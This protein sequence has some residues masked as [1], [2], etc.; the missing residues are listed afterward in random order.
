MNVCSSVSVRVSTFCSVVV[1]FVVTFFIITSN[2]GYFGAVCVVPMI[3]FKCFH[4]SSMFSISSSLLHLFSQFLLFSIFIS[5]FISLLCWLYS[6]YSI[7][8]LFLTFF[9]YVFFVFYHV[10]YQF[11]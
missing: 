5:L 3:C 7:V 11:G 4:E 2:V 10:C 1:I 9:P 6:V 8:F